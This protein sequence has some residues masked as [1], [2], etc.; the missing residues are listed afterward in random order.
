VKKE[1]ERVKKEV[2]EEKITEKGS[3]TDQF[4]Y[5]KGITVFFFF[6]AEESE[7]GKTKS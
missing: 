5:H 1:R 6:F 2:K 4:T 3:V 7:G